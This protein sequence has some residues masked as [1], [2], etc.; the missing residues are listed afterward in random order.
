MH[1]LPSE[2]SFCPERSPLPC[3]RSGYAV[4][5]FTIVFSLFWMALPKLPFPADS[6]TETPASEP[7]LAAQG[8]AGQG[9]TDFFLCDEGGR[10]VVYTCTENGLPDKRLLRT[11]IYVNLLPEADAI[12]LKQGFYVSGE[13][14]LRA[15]LEDLGG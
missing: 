7:G 5:I 11:G 6:G 15:Q 12:R 1:I 13:T 3:A 4:C 2:T 8:R 10:V 9:S 14:A